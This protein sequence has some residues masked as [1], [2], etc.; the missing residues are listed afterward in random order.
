MCS[1]H[2]GRAVQQNYSCINIYASL[3]ACTA[4][5]GYNSGYSMVTGPNYIY[6]VLSCI[7]LFLVYIYSVFIVYGRISTAVN[8]LIHLVVVY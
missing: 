7:V 5:R 4:H 8:G 6:S 1:V 2:Q 3:N